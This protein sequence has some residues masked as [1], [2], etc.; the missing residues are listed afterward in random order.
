MMFVLENKHKAY[1]A[2]KN[3]FSGSIRFWF[4]SDPAVDPQ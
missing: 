2:D 3:F 1:Q 4:S